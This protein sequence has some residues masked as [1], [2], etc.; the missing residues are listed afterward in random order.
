MIIGVTGKKQVGKDTMADYLVDNYGF[1]KFAFADPI[2]K[3]GLL[4]GF[5][6][7]QMDCNKDEINTKWRMSWRKFAQTIG[8]N[9]FR[10]TFNSNTWLI[11]M[12]IKLTKNRNQDIIIPDVRF[13]NEA[14]FIRLLGGNI[15]GVS[16]DTGL[17]DRHKSEKGICCDLID[18]N[19]ENN[20]SIYDYHSKIKRLVGGL[21]K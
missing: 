11:I 16:R 18:F 14:I 3:I 17:L 7:K 9:V 10:D 13:N 19:I 12:K 8:T 2:R 1:K 21:K 15:I 20:S 4:F 6:K 5:T